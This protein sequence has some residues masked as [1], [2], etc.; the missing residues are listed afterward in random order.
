MGRAA[1]SRNSDFEASREALLAKLSLQALKPHGARLSFRELAA[2]AG[3]SPP[4]VRH[5]FG[6]RAQVLRDV[7]AHLNKQG[8]VYL[9]AAA[10]HP[11]ANLRESLKWLLDSIVLGW[12]FRVGA[13]HQLGLTAGLGDAALGPAYINEIL[14]PTLQA[15]EV[16]LKRHIARGQLEKCDVRHAALE[17]LAPVVLGLL[18]QGNLFGATC[19]PLDLD[20]FLKDHLTRFLRGYRKR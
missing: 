17:L 11:I 4:T 7:L 20:A 5:Y 16:R 8:Q 1:G 10:N 18:H 15:A 6:D 12:Q 14:E 13:V 19:R 3:V 2:G 9:D